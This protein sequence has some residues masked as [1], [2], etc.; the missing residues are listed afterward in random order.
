[1]AALY[2]RTKTSLQLR[3]LVTT[4]VLLAAAL[5]IAVFAFERVAHTVVT[6]A[7][8]SHLSARAKEVQD[9]VARFQ[10]E[11][12]LTVHEWA[13]SRQMQDSFD[14]GDPKFAEDQAIRSSPRTTSAARSRT[15]AAPSPPRCSSRSTRRW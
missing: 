6:E 9:S 5:A 15:R 8:H 12:A 3:L 2:H 13:S 11:R 4:V 1:M 14:L 7:V 10:R